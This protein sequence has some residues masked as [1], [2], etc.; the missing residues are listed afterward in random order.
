MF[1][2][3]S[4]VWGDVRNRQAILYGID[5]N[6][7]VEN[8]LLGN[9]EAA[10]S[11]LQ[12]THPNYNEAKVVYDHDPEK[13]K[14]LLEESGLS[15]K[16]ITITCTYHDWVKKCTPLIKEDLDALGLKVSLDEGQ[17]AGVYTQ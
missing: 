9:G 8:G 1:N 12:S 7:L 17:S 13:A 14:S 4:E 10:T 6:K 11:F 3:G 5:M 16:S 15:G 2:M